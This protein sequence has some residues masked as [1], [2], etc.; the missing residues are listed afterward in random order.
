MIARCEDSKRENFRYYGGLGVTVCERWRKSF[1]AFLEDMGERPA[2]KTID[3]I[4]TYGI[5]EPGNCR[6]ATAKEQRANQR[7]R[8]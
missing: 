2:G 4:D 8:A 3:R 1:S 5:Y 7:R 6:W